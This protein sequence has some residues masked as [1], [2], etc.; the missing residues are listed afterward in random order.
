[1]RA[2]GSGDLL[3]EAQS[4]AVAVLEKLLEEVE[5]SEKKAGGPGY[6]GTAGE[7]PPEWEPIPPV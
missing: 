1:M 5:E 7:N 4:A 2:R 3:T 6:D